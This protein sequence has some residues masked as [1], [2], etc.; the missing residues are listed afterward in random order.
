MYEEVTSL[1]KSEYGIKSNAKGLRTQFTGMNQEYS[2]YIKN[3]NLSARGGG[4]DA[5]YGQPEYYKELHK[6][7]IILHSTTQQ[8]K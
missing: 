1:A 2:L 7:C 4:D 5:L 8:A 3:W 6:W